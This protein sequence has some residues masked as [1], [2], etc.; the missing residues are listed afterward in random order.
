M[1]KS[2]CSALLLW[3]LSSQLLGWAL[4]ENHSVNGG[5]TIIPVDSNHQPEAYYQGKR[6]PIIPSVK[7]NQWLLVVAIPLTSR[8][9][10]HYLDLTKPIQSTIPFQVSDK[11]Y[12]TQYLRIK[13]INKVDPQPQDLVRIKNETKKLAQI[14]AHYSNQN[15]FQK[16]YTAP[17]NGEISSLFGLKRV[18][19]KQPKDPHS[20]LDIA[21]PEGQPIHAV[22]DGVV[23]NIGDYFFTG[24]TVIIDHGMGVFSLYAHLSKI[25]VTS[26]ERIK[27]GKELGLVG[28]TGRVTGP[29]LHW[30]MIVNQTLVDPLLFVPL[31]HIALKPTVKPQKLPKTN[32]HS[33]EKSW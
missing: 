24:K 20:G 5:L 32:N 21:S 17:L 33:Q 30:S 2:I 10:I 9:P 27:Q 3:S 25:T 13:D 22:N 12:T 7:P 19:N 16:K 15:P 28:M 4:P 18:Y 31:R 23:A 29:H 14:Y 8:E 11:F 1:I 26:G 6:I